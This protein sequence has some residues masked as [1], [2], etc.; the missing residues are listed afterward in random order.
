MDV[1]GIGGICPPVHRVGLE[2]LCGRGTGTGRMVRYPA[3]VGLDPALR[4]RGGRGVRAD[5]SRAQPDQRPQYGVG[6]W[7]SGVARHV[8][9]RIPY[10]HPAV[11]VSDVL[12]RSFGSCGRDSSTGNLDRPG[13]LRSRHGQRVHS[14]LYSGGP[15]HR[16]PLLGGG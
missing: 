14:R 2:L 13:R 7:G 12:L 6:R 11:R 16:G 5:C 1:A 4:D 8:A 15:E 9:A 3:R 10:D